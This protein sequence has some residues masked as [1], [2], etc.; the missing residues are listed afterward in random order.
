MGKKGKGKKV[1]FLTDSAALAP[2][3]VE[4]NDIIATP[5]GV[6]CTV[7][8]V[9]DGALWLKWPGGIESPASPAPAK[10]RNKSELETYGYSRRPQSAHI[11]R[12]I[13]ERLRAQYQQR[14]YGAPGPRTAALKVRCVPPLF[15]TGV[16]LTVD[17]C[18]LA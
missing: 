18:L 14:R 16:T 17:A 1:E 13:D 12:S 11:Q 9:K 3:E 2:F 5:L 4:M 10:A 7:I 6:T 8:G 15:Y